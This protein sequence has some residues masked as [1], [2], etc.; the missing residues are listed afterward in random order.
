MAWYISLADGQGPLLAPRKLIIG[1]PLLLSLKGP[2]RPAGEL[3]AIDRS[4][5]G[6]NPGLTDLGSRV[7][8]TYVNSDSLI[9]IPTLGAPNSLQRVTLDG[10]AYT[11][12]FRWNSRENTNP[13]IVPVIVSEGVSIHV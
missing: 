6:I 11:L 1:Y 5:S 10:R 13:D 7:I 4:D 12:G 9:K 8:L 3:L 2:R